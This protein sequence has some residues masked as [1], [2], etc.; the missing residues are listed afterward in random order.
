VITQRARSN[1]ALLPVLAASL[2]LASMAARPAQAQIKVDG[3]FV[4]AYLEDGNGASPKPLTHLTDPN[5]TYGY[6]PDA[7]SPTLAGW[8]DPLSH[9]SFLPSFNA[10]S[11]PGTPPAPLYASFNF[12]LFFEPTA[13]RATRN[14][15][16]AWPAWGGFT[17]DVSAP[18][19]API[20]FSQAAWS[21]RGTTVTPT[22]EDVDGATISLPKG[23]AL[24]R[25]YANFNTLTGNNDG[26]LTILSTKESPTISYHWFKF[27]HDFFGFS[28]VTGYGDIAVV[29]G[30]AEVVGANGVFAALKPATSVPS[31][32]G[33]GAAVFSGAMRRLPPVVRYPGLEYNDV[34]FLEDP[35]YNFRNDSGR[36]LKYDTYEVAPKD[37]PTQ[38]GG[39]RTQG[40]YKNHQEAREFALGTP[41]TPI[42][43]ANDNPAIPGIAPILVTSDADAYSILWA[44][45]AKT[46]T[47][48]NRSPLG[49]ARIQLAHQLLTAELNRRLFGPS[50]ALDTLL[51]DAINAMSGTDISLILSLQGQLDAY[52]NAGEAAS[53]NSSNAKGGPASSLGDNPLFQ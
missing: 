34:N 18:G 52:N 42:L 38:G 19:M 23:S 12:G 3:I 22:T 53:L 26:V 37:R 48:A 36:F 15:S 13:N 43:L 2:A 5:W 1:S 9:Y 16:T 17:G 39:S 47:G 46:S 50:A 45:I 11:L 29:A 10:N 33:N 51:F 32:S 28:P 44:N 4:G 25:L 6:R 21:T 49:Q 31:S 30:R 8:P 7:L 20:K 24:I 35:R 41:I 14:S 40:Y 27:A